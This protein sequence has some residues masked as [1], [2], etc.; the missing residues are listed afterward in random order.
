[1]LFI[2]SAIPLQLKEVQLPNSATDLLSK[3]GDTIVV[4]HLICFSK[5]RVEE[6]PSLLI[7]RVH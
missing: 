4:L 3:E 5:D 1:M 2:V 7:C 6:L